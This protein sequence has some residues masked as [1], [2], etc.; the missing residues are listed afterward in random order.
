MRST[1]TCQSSRRLTSK[2]ESCPE[3]YA[4]WLL[5]ETV[6]LLDADFVTVTD[7]VK[8][9]E[10]AWHTKDHTVV[11]SVELPHVQSIKTTD[12]AATSDRKIEGGSPPFRKMV[13]KLGRVV[14]LEGWTKVQADLDSMS[15]LKDGAAKTF[16]HPSGNSFAVLVSA[17][18]VDDSVD[19]YG[20]RVW[21]MSL[22]ELRKW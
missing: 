2:W 19:A 13:G 14:E 20:R 3:N 10:F 5:A 12:P 7:S 15:A 1:P 18:N 21:T 16:L 9:A 6:T 8:L 17:S 22:V 11:G 4:G